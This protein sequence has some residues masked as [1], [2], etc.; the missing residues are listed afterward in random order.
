MHFITG[1]AFNGKRAW[2]KKTYEWNEDGGW[3]S[4][5]QNDQMP[6]DLTNIH[7][8]RIVL[9]GIEI[10]LQKLLETNDVNQVREIW[11]SCLERWL[12][13][14]SA[15]TGRQLVAIGTDITK[16]IVPIETADRFWRD[17]TGWVYQD[18]A[19]RSARVDVIW[20]GI[21]HRIK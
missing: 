1:G 20:Y 18:T 2:V 15:G 3:I 13:W 17:L 19:A 7:H 6:D 11:N 9:E 10:W 12:S 14:E 16:G 5:Y 4:A 21:S 8:E